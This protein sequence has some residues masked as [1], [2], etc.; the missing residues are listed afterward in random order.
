MTNVAHIAASWAL[1][2][3]EIVSLIVYF[4]PY[5]PSLHLGEAND[6][7]PRQILSSASLVCR[8][9]CEQLRPSLWEELTLKSR[10]ELRELVGLGRRVSA[11]VRAVRLLR[12]SEED[13][14]PAATALFP[15][16]AAA[17][18]RLTRICWDISSWIASR[19][20]QKHWSTE[21]VP[22][23]ACAHMSSFRAVTLLTLDTCAFRSLE[24]FMRFVSSLPLLE[25]LHCYDVDWTVPSAGWS[26]PRR[27]K[28]SGR[29]AHMK[30][31]GCL[32]PWLLL[33]LFSPSSRA[34]RTDVRHPGLPD[35][36]IAVLVSLIRHAKYERPDTQTWDLWRTYG[37][38]N[39]NS[40]RIT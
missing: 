39:F 5:Y 25:T 26:P 4:L 14:I 31:R 1:L 35:E 22:S 11:W 37:K 23:R 30:V 12:S 13:W 28:V 33:W 36:D 29:L 20:V 2:P 8:H 38:L 32:A 40:C 15:A 18:P 3:P 6:P 19:G 17:L 9:W 24:L 10:A 7:T 34:V 27:A 16:L 21:P